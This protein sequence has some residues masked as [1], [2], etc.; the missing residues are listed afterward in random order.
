MNKH[1]RPVHLYVLACIVLFLSPHMRAET[2]LRGLGP[3]PDS[4]DI[5]LAQGVAALNVLRDIRE[6]LL[7]PGPDGRPAAGVAEDWQMSDDGLEYRFRLRESACWSNGDTVTAKDFLRAWNALFAPG[8]VAPN[9]E[10]LEAMLDLD[11]H[12]K[13][14]ATGEHE[15]QIKLR[16][17]MPWLPYLLSHPVSYPLHESAE[18]GGRGGPFN[19]AYR[20]EKW[21]PNSTIELQKN[22]CYWDAGQTKMEQVNYFPIEDPGSELS[23]YRAHELHISETIPAGRYD[24]I[25]ENL[26]G[27]LRIHAYLGSFFLG[28]NLRRNALAGSVGLRRALA[29]AIDR[30]KLTRLVLASGEQPAFSLVPPGLSGY[31]PALMPLAEASQQEREQQARQYFHEAGY[32]SE[33]PLHLELRFN[34]SSIH[35]RTAIAVAAMWKQVL[36]VTTQMVNEEWKVFIN[37]RRQ[38]VIT[39]VFRGGW[40]ADYPDPMTFLNLFQSDGAM[41]WSGFR[42]P[43]YD[44]M[45]ERAKNMPAGPDRQL[46]LGRLEARLWESQPLIPLY[47]YV[48]RHLVKPSVQGFVPNVQDI[49]LSQYLEVQTS[50]Q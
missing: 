38:A 31:S 2:L 8:T 11:G 28:L 4:L 20:L 41:N 7:R 34:T 18:S 37:N 45:L 9:A 1:K 25:M 16:Y 21:V 29:L 26:P 35:R 49:H 44:N 19:G 14:Q 12:L 47:Y 32:S 17:P 50:G 33:K 30:D 39:E 22:H 6:G 36:G 43:E 23:R 24:W 40:I 3:E 10:L 27:E 48:S 15:L 42:S 13:A 5:H 46:L